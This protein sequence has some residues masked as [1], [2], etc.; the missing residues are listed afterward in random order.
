MRGT[1][2]ADDVKESELRSSGKKAQ[3]DL[4]VKYMGPE[5][6]PFKCSRCEYYIVGGACEKVEGTID[7]DGCCNLYE[8]AE[9]PETEE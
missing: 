5:D 4:T 9:E 8:E 3:D 2:D 6:G 1:S 7:P